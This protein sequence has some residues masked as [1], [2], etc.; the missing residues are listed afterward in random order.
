MLAEGNCLLVDGRERAF[1]EHLE[2]AKDA[3]VGECAVPAAIRWL[4]RAGDARCVGHVYREGGEK[5][6]KAPAKDDKKDDPEGSLGELLVGG[7]G[8]T[9]IMVRLCVPCPGIAHMLDGIIGWIRGDK[10][11]RWVE[12]GKEAVGEGSWA[13]WRGGEPLPESVEGA[14]AWSNYGEGDLQKQGEQ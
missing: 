11:D 14:N 9:W 13:E 7:E 12:E 4:G 6:E 5:G 10:G 8:S 3:E 2:E 1:V